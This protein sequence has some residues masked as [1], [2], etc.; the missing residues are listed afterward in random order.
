MPR[1]LVLLVFLYGLGVLLA[2]RFE[3]GGETALLSV[4]AALIVAAIAYFAARQAGRWLLVPLFVL[5]GMAMTGLTVD[6]TATPLAQWE[7]RAVTVAGMVVR[8]ADVRPDRVLYVLEVRAARL[9][10]ETMRPGGRVLVSHYE[11][12]AIYGYGDLLEVRGVLRRPLTP[13]NPGEFDYRA[14]LERQGITHLVTVRGPGAVVHTGLDRGNPVVYQ[15]LTLKERLSAGLDSALYPEQAALVRGITLGVRGGIEPAVREAFTAT[16]VVHILSVSG[17]HVGF[18]LGLTLLL[19]RF[20]RLNPFWTVILVAGVLA[21]YAIMVGFKPSVI[22][23]SVMALL[24]LAAHQLGRWRD[25]PTALALAALVI[26][27]GNPLALFDPGFQLSFTATWGILYLGP[28][29]VRGM[30]RIAERCDLQWWKA[31][32]GWFVAVPLAAQLGTLPLVAYYY[33]LVSPVAL[34]ANLLTVPLVGLIFVLGV[35][36]SFLGAFL[37]AVAWLTGPATGALVDVFLALVRFFA[38]LPGAFFYVATP[39]LLLVVGWYLACYGAGLFAQPG[40]WRERLP[41]LTGGLDRAGRRSVGLLVG[42]LVMVG[43]FL[44]WPTTPTTPWPGVEV[45]FV[46]VGQGDCTVIFTRT[47]STVVIDTGGWRGELE[48]ESGVGDKVVLPYLRR[49]GVKEI[50]LL[51]LTHPHE[52]HVGGAR[53]LKDALVIKRVVVAPVGGREAPPPGYLAL[54]EEFEAKG[55]PVDEVWAGDRIQVDREV[56]L[57]VLGPTF[58]LLA[59]TRSDLNNNSAVLRLDYGAH[60]FLFAGDIEQEAQARLLLRE[61]LRVNVLKVPHH[62]SGEFVPD[63]FHAVRPEV[64]VISCGRNNRF[65]HPHPDTLAVLRE[66]GAAIYRTDLDGAVIVR[67]DG[68]SLHIETG[69]ERET[70]DP[71]A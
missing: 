40:S 7:D 15:A 5:L 71:A 23:A 1:P 10:E 59:G 6:K 34:P 38:G 49:H 55:I 46:D 12:D 3:L 53:A 16:G 22:R 62:G 13:G 47:G 39:S 29:L 57:R 54:L 17:L 48:G 52:D 35:I 9:G 70:L 14:Y 25:W 19:T 64:A 37:P 36:T 45:H 68:R 30:E 69:R 4:G 11:P 32:H 63:F 44:A 56:T 8:D 27:V 50:D 43:I 42:G 66:V 18:L 2:L 26:L 41:G 33:N 28:L 58:P 51:V 31:A 20:V 21:F 65:G 24:L 67:T 60:S 61:N